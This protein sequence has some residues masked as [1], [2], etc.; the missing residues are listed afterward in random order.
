MQSLTLTIVEGQGW[1]PDPDGQTVNWNNTVFTTNFRNPLKIV[2]G[3][4]NYG[5]GVQWMVNLGEVPYYPLEDLG[6]DMVQPRLPPDNNSLDQR[7]FEKPTLFQKNGTGGAIRYEDVVVEM[8]TDNGTSW[9][10]VERNFYTLLED[11]MG[12]VFNPL[13]AHELGYKIDNNEEFGGV[14]YWQA[15]FDNSLQ[16]RVLC[17][18]KSDIRVSALRFNAGA[19]FPLAVKRVYDNPS[20]RHLVYNPHISDSIYYTNFPPEQD[21]TDN[22][23]ALSTLTNSQAANTDAVMF[24]GQAVVVLGNVG[25]YRP[26]QTVNGIVGRDVTFATPATIVQVSYDFPN[27]HVHLT[28]DNHRMPV[29]LK[30]KIAEERTAREHKLGI[31]PDFTPAQ[32]QQVPFMPMSGPHNPDFTRYL[33]EKEGG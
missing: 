15:L 2:P 33:R 5:V 21:N 18:I 16:I 6:K 8:S 10:I 28:L 22:T 4:G 20:Y 12:V 26:G 3:T 7:R 29:V 11:G 30:A 24:S 19:S 9:G 23:A 17:A 31:G 32:G 25:D 1:A 27:Q 14:S 13:T